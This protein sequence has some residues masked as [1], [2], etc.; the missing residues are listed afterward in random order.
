MS[1]AARLSAS[2]PTKRRRERVCS[3]WRSSRL[4]SSSAPGAPKYR[5]ST[6]KSSC[7]RCASRAMM[8]NTG[9]NGKK[10]QAP[11]SITQATKPTGER[12]MKM[13]GSVLGLSIRLYPRISRWYL[14]LLRA[15]EPLLF[16]P[17]GPSAD[18]A[19]MQSRGP[20]SP[21]CPTTDLRNI[22]HGLGRLTGESQ[23]PHLRPRRL[24]GGTS[25]GLRVVAWG[26]SLR[27]DPGA[28]P[29]EYGRQ[30]VSPPGGFPIRIDREPTGQIDFPS[31]AVRTRD[32]APAPRA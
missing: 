4:R 8:R 16:P 10:P 32:C 25:Y 3:H 24:S 19:V 15:T 22:Q 23:P 29:Q 13:A 11:L 12:V 30:C 20:A 26:A 18:C 21:V 2:T 5:S 9:S 1:I 7:E 17:R 14:S 6:I 27:A 28:L 31:R